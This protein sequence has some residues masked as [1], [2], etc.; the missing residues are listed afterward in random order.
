MTRQEAHK[1]LFQRTFLGDE[2]LRRLMHALGNNA[3]EVRVVG[4]AVRN[5]LRQI[6]VSDLDLACIHL[7]Q[8]V[9]ERAEKAGF[10]TVPTGIEHGT[11]TIIGNEVQYEVT[12][13]REDI[14]TD[15]RHAV[16]RFGTDWQS[17]MERRDFTMNA[18]CVDKDGVLHDLVSG[19]DDCLSGHVRFIG[20]AHQRIAEDALRILRFF[21]FSAHFGNGAADEAGLAAANDGV[22]LLNHLSVERIQAELKK[23]WSAP[24]SDQ[25]SIV[26]NSASKVFEAIG[27][28]MRGIDFSA[29]A[30]CDRTDWELRALIL[31]RHDLG[32]LLQGVQRLKFSRADNARLRTLME[33]LDFFDIFDISDPKQV[34]NAAYRFGRNAVHDVVYVLSRFEKNSTQK[35][36]VWT[37][38]LE[39]W[40]VPKFPVKAADLIQLG[41]APGPRL[42]QYLVQLEQSWIDAQFV[43]T[44]DDLV[45]MAGQMI[46]S[47]Q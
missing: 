23:L 34:Q 14:E 30:R 33:L 32:A 22:A 40:Q 18:L 10:R 2:Q 42:G 36:S 25:L 21:R 31:W 47:D 44:R 6:P 3:E 16:V 37:K 38:P 9:I 1:S 27:W 41:L 13:L 39:T 15:G 7:P 35:Y 45:N 26:L 12:T 29:L 43:P 5:V 4:G 17:D 20:R 46:E 19:L 8:E 28:D 24:R 11:V